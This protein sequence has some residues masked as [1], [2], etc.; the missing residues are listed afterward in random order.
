MSREAVDGG[1]VGERE[2]EDPIR[3]DYSWVDISHLELNNYRK[4][5]QEA[6]LRNQIWNH[7]VPLELKDLSSPQRWWLCKRCYIDGKVKMYK[8]K[9]TL[10]AI[11]RH[12]RGRHKGAI[13]DNNT[14]TRT[15]LLSYL[16]DLNLDPNNPAHQDILE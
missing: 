14:D 10:S 13:Q 15:L 5:L 6:Q 1:G 8:S 3:F 4:L 2:E 12:L 16:E 7:G 11:K 9:D